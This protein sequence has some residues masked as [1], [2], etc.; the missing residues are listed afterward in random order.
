MFSTRFYIRS[1]SQAINRFCRL[2]KSERL[3]FS[4]SLSDEYTEKPEYP[5]IL[6]LTE[7][8]IKHRNLEFENEKHQ[9]LHT[10]EE[11]LFAINLPRYYGWES[12]I[13]KEGVIPYNF[14]PLVQYITRTKF[15]ETSKLHID[16]NISDI[17]ED[18]IEDIRNQ[19]QEAIIL[20]LVNRRHRYEIEGEKL[21]ETAQS[22]ILAKN[23]ID[24]IHRIII[25]SLVSRFPHLLEAETD[26]DPRIEAFWKVGNFPPDPETYEN[27]KND[28]EKYKKERKTMLMRSREIEKIAPEKEIDHWI[29]YF[30]EPIIQLRHSSP[31]PPLVQESLKA[32]KEEKIEE[33]S[34]SPEEEKEK[35]IDFPKEG[36]D[37]GY[38]G[39]EKVR[40]H[41]TNIPGFWPGNPN[42]FGILSYHKRGH[43]LGRPPHFGKNDEINAL[44]VQGILSGFGWLMA[45]AAYQGFNTFIEITYPLTT[46]TVITDGRVFSFYTYQLNTLLMHDEHMQTNTKENI[47]YGSQEKNLYKSIEGD[48]IIGWDDEVLKTLLSFYINVPKKREG[49]N[50]KPYVNDEEQYICDIK[51]DKRREWLHKQFRHMYSNRKRHLVPYEIYDWEQ[52][53]KIKFNLRPF[54]ARRRPFELDQ[55]PLEERKFSDHVP[56][57]IKKSLRD[58]LKK[59]QKFEDTYYP[60]I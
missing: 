29:Q 5:P 26:Y 37:P 13:L 53:Y 18:I 23:V 35:I 31:L 10:V 38:N 43:L 28:I 58:P 46:S 24:Q 45:Q 49:V 17:S 4:T 20:E 48:K 16:T 6:D 55:N 3:C 40:R 34:D 8:E 50:L 60:D 56:A 42:E 25:T 47:C 44:H 52:I 36:Y 11:K 7:K 32:G 33:V 27:R 19:I 39:I 14:L 12:L 21:S 15:V 9:K 54:D 30:G 41:G 22:D 1:F 2:K 57:Y 51:D 59:K